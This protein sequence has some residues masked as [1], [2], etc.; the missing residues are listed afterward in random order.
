LWRWVV[1]VTVL[2]ERMAPGKKATLLGKIGAALAVAVLL[3]VGLLLF[4][5]VYNLL[6]PGPARRR[7]RTHRP[8]EVILAPSTSDDGAASL[9]MVLRY[10]GKRV[11]LD[12]IRPMVARVDNTATALELVNAAKPYDLTIVGY[13]LEKAEEWAGVKLPCI[14]HLYQQRGDFPRPLVNDRGKFV[15]LEAVRGNDVVIVDPTDGG[16][17]HETRGEFLAFSSGVV[18]VVE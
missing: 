9:T 16:R 8:V 1:P 7:S 4:V 14:A 5:T 13:K 3:I 6:A 12:D 15:V 10:H 11:T 18:L 2:L 17:R